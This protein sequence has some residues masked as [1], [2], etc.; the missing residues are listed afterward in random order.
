[1]YEYLEKCFNKNPCITEYQTESCYLRIV[2][3]NPCEIE[4]TNVATLCHHPT[5][6]FSY[7]NNA[8]RAEGCGGGNALI[9]SPNLLRDPQ[10]IEKPSCFR[11]SYSEEERDPLNFIFWREK[12]HTVSRPLSEVSEAGEL[13]PKAR[14]DLRS[15]QI[16]LSTRKQYK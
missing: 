13:E 14:P 8:E 15:A 5:L 11:S 6:S 2:F 3:V 4:N 12:R 16:T 10:E 7:S 1:M 9:S